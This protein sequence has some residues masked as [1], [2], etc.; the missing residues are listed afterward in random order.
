[1][2][3]ADLLSRFIYIQYII[4]KNPY[5]DVRDIFLNNEIEVRKI[6]PVRN[7]ITHFEY[8]DLDEVNELQF[9]CFPVSFIRKSIKTHSTIRISQV[10]THPALAPDS[11]LDP[12]CTT[13]CNPPIRVR[14]PRHRFKA[15][16]PLQHLILGAC[17]VPFR[18]LVVNA[19]ISAA[20]ASER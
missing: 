5:V 16:L 18:I 8:R 17:S 2:D 7:D 9:S 13:D 14:H 6:A 10:G 4:R 19:S 20:Y 1:V 3:R 11:F 15:I 12:S